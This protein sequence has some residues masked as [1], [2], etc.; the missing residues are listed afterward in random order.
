MQREVLAISRLLSWEGKDSSDR[1]FNRM[2]ILDL[3]IVQDAMLEAHSRFLAFETARTSFC[4][5]KTYQTN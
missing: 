2:D 1:K 5:P 3:I 4:I